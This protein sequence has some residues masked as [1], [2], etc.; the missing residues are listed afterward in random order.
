M[1][2]RGIKC[3][4]KRYRPLESK[5]FLL[6]QTTVLKYRGLNVHREILCNNKISCGLELAATDH[7]SKGI[8]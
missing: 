7:H 1:D 4:V 2:K 3:S 5:Y 8:K 6:F